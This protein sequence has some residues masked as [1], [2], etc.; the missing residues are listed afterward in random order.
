MR[1]LGCQ[2]EG[3]SRWCQIEM[4]TD[5]RE[6]GWVN[7]RF[8]TSKSGQASQFPSPLRMERVRL[9]PGASNAEN[10]DE[11]AAGAIVINPLNARSGE[12]LWVEFKVSGLAVVYRIFNA[13][14][15]TFLE[16]WNRDGRI[17]NK[18]GK[19]EITNSN[20]FSVATA[21]A[22]AER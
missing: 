1:N 2:T 3:N 12:N 9:Q 19:L 5:M 16:K 8:L 18:F 7:A 13:D 22:A 14:G 4:M 21:P 15:S 20:Y 11:I 17:A 10:F 6:R